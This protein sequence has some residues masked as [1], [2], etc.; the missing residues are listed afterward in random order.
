MLQQTQVATVIPYYQRFMDRFPTV[1][2]LAQAPLDRVLKSWEGLGYYARGRNLHRAAGQV[3]ETWGGRVPDEI[4]ALS[5]LP[6]IGRST[7]GAIASLAYGRRAPI[8]DGNVR[9]VLCRVYAIDGDPRRPSVQKDLWGLSEQ[10]IDQGDPYIINQ[11]L[12]DLGATLCTPKIPKC[13][14][15]P[16]GPLCL[17]HRDGIQD[18]LPV[19]PPTRKIP[20]HTVAVGVIRKGGKILITQRP[21]EGL[22]GGL[23]EFPGGKVEEGETPVEA[24]VREIREELGI[25][26]SVGDPIAAV[27]HA[28]SHFRITL[29]AF[30]CR[31]VRGTPKT[32]QPY[33]WIVPDELHHYA[34]PTANRKIIRELAGIGGIGKGLT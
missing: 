10:L 20:H 11:A 12:M 34:F 18:K 30:H 31:H 17:A 21:P 22:L 13:T 24:V 27:R 16:M 6:G 29:H 1:S 8:L 32:V 15:C 25:R 9:R 33:R 5:S 23:W 4:D 7:A 14:D 28:Y 3:M 26:V 19:K 2:D